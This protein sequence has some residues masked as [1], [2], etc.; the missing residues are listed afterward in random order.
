M[1]DG[2]YHIQ[3]TKYLFLDYIKDVNIK[4]KTQEKNLLFYFK[5]FICIKYQMN[6]EM[7]K[8]FNL[9]CNQRK[10]MKSILQNNDF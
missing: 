10:E 1:K 5:F 3:N 9:L 6:L 7:F 4:R 2:V 8:I